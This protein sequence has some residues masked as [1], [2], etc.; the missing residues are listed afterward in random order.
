[1]VERQREVGCGAAMAGG[2]VLLGAVKG[3][4]QCDDTA[5]RGL[6]S[7]DERATGRSGC[8][9]GAVAFRRVTGLP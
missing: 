3:E 9:W 7:V 6:E 5:G 2:D 8:Y 4:K 1:M